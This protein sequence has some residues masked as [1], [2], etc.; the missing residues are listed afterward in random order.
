MIPFARIFAFASAVLLLAGTLFAAPKK[1]EDISLAE[2]LEMALTEGSPFYPEY[3][4][5]INPTKERPDKVI[6]TWSWA[7]AE[8]SDMTDFPSENNP[9]NDAAKIKKL[10]AE[11]DAF[12]SGDPKTT[13]AAPAAEDF[14]GV[15]AGEVELVERKIV[16]DPAIGGWHSTG[17]WAPPGQKITVIL[18]GKSKTPISLRIGSQSD[19]L[20]WNHLEKHHNG[21]LKRMPRLTNGVRISERRVEFANPM[22]GLIYIDVHNVAEKQR[23]L[24]MT[25]RG[26]VPA[27]LYVFGDKP[28][29]KENLT[30]AAE[31]KEQLEKYKAPWGEIQ[32]P[33]LTFTLPL[34][35]LRQMKLP[36][37]VSKNLQRGMAVQDWIVAWDL[38]K[39]RLRQPM[40]F[41]LDRQIALG[42][43]HSGYPAMGYM[44]W[45]NCTR[46]GTL[47]TQGSWG[48]W[49]ELGHNH[50]LVTPYFCI[51]SSG[52]TEVTVNVFSTI[53]QVAGCEVPYEKAWDG[54]GIDEASMRPSL[55]EFFRSGQTFN[56]CE[57]VRVKLYFY[58]EL[59]REL[60]FETFRG[61]GVA[62]QREPFG[63]L[64]DQE[65]WDWVLTTL[66]EVSG[67]NLAPYFKAW[68]IDVS[69][70]ALKKVEKYA[71]WDYLENYPDRILNPKPE[72]KKSRKSKKADAG[73]PPPASEKPRR[74]PKNNKS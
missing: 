68:R 74:T 31:W 38:T 37:R 32:T 28:T 44:A 54:G 36:R 73:T 63:E 43:G 14:P 10:I 16:I 15:P 39:S 12:M 27:P 1:G 2:V 34:D 30:T 70:R 61:M 23:P 62:Y 48:L 41:V 65:K 5:E 49:H 50:Q 55:A 52:L 13:K 25:I 66:S 45:G 67:K 71:D 56:A 64:S 18:S 72:K 42:W 7:A 21:T 59:M 4:D 8:K 17:L 51:A 69:D 57:D 9:W 40:R 20:S 3:R 35:M 60:G 53:S 29:K 19:F 11:S 58:V 24:R 33:R 46:T 6:G 22:G 26:G 47:T